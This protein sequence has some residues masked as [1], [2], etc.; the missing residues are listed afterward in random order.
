MSFYV[1]SGNDRVKIQEKIQKILGKDYEI[2]DGATLDATSLM[3]ICSSA[4]LFATERKILIKDLTPAKK[5][6]SA[7]QPVECEAVASCKTPSVDLYGVL[8]K[9]A[10]TPHKIV[11]WESNTSLKKSFKDF[12]KLPQVK[13]EKIDVVETVDK[14]AIFKVFDKALVNGEVAVKEYL[15]LK[16]DPYM[17]VGALASWAVNKYNFRGG[18]REKRIV[19]AVA[20]LDMQTKT[21]KISPD[22]LVEAFLARMNKI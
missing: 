2:F 6:N 8:M 20:E 9:Y 22:L 10:K 15:E 18:E 21:L 3:E 4:S 16:S 13:K 14:F 19:K 17:A 1:F 11:I 12:C 5:S 7:T